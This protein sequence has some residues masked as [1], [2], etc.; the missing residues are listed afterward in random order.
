M[1]PKTRLF[2]DE[3]PGALSYRIYVRREGQTD[4]VLWRESGNAA[5]G[6]SVTLVPSEMSIPEGSLIY[7]TIAAMD[8]WGQEGLSSEELQV[9]IPLPAPQNLRLE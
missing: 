6:V 2:W 8:D 3:V 5:Q 1:A 9:K 7:I 4:A